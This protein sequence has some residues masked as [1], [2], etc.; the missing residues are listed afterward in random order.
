[1]TLTG[2]TGR[3]SDVSGTL[4]VVSEVIPISFDGVTLVNSTEGTVSGQISY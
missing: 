4:T 3:F 1:M 2:G